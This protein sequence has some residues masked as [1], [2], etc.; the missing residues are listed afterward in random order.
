MRLRIYELYIANPCLV[1]HAASAWKRAQLHPGEHAHSCA[2]LSK[3]MHPRHGRSAMRP[4]Q[5]DGL[6][7]TP[8]IK[9]RT[10]LTGEC[11]STHLSPHSALHTRVCTRKH[12]HCAQACQCMRA[13]RPAQRAFSGTAPSNIHMNV[14]ADALSTR[15]RTS[16]RT[17]ALYILCAR[18]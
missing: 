13:P 8:N 11:K 10:P 3:C 9:A 17:T 5:Q 1:K 14:R 18:P 15:T 12:A 6:M 7:R 16:P 4:T 2:C